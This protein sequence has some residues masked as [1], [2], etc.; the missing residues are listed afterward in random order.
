MKIVIAP[1]KF[2]NCLAAAEVARAIAEGIR[3]VDRSIEI[4]ECPMA[5][6]GEGTVAAL[7][8]ATNGKIQLHRVTGPLATMKV[9]APVGLLG[10]GTT[11][12]V[13]MASAS[14]LCLLNDE[15]RDPVRTT[16][17]G[18]GELLRAACQA[19]GIRRVILGIGGSATTDAGVGAAQAWG[20]RFSLASGQVYSTDDR[21]LTGGDL[22]RLR[23]IEPADNARGGNG[24]TRFTRRARASRR[25]TPAR[26]IGHESA[27]KFIDHHGI[28]FIVACDV[29]NPLLGENGAAAIFAPQKGASPQE[30]AQ[31][32]AGLQ[33][34]V[35]RTGR[36]DLADAAGAGAAG[37]MGF[38]MM[39]FFDA[40]LRA[41]IEIVIDATRL[42]QRLHG[43]D[44]CITGEGTLDEQSLSGKT[45]IGVARLCKQLQVP[46]IGICG[47]LGAEAERFAQEGMMAAFSAVNRP[48]SLE[49]AM[50]NAPS[51]LQSCVANVLRLWTSTRG[52]SSC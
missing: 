48:L 13:E 31:L 40:I 14:G 9:D 27:G 3:S 17:Y 50:A 43:A 1:D 29:G 33:K 45:A 10:D 21:K 6:G 15:Q 39:V 41:G 7:V 46:C 18:T 26:A 20:V 34:V 16:S 36:N 28:E 32:E 37:G 4:D 2:K 12:V 8:S 19:P 38:G 24:G 47:S 51:L 42:R 25:S 49:D 5:D 44:L 35:E 11:A 22:V 30:V 52:A 23:S